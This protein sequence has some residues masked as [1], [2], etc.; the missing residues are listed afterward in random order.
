MRSARR[1]SHWAASRCWY[2]TGC[3]PTRQSRRIWCGILTAHRNVCQ[4][5]LWKCQVGKGEQWEREPK[6]RVNS[7]RKPCV[8][9]PLDLKRSEK[10]SAKHLSSNRATLCSGTFPFSP[11]FFPGRFCFIT[12]I[13]ERTHSQTTLVLMLNQVCSRA[14]LE[15]TNNPFHVLSWGPVPVTTWGSLFLVR[16][17]KITVLKITA[18]WS[19]LN[20]CSWSSICS[21]P[22]FPRACKSG[23][24]SRS[25][26]KLYNLNPNKFLIYAN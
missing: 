1:P 25:V 5:D 13:Q 18:H 20:H 19:G 16:G 12:A 6:G 15:A 22:Q 3:A 2:C 23:A 4:Q 14:V 9:Y 11:H 26:T 10:Q 24:S 8:I 17:N 21:D 7:A